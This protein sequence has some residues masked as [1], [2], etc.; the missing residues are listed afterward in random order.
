MPEFIEISINFCRALLQYRIDIFEIQDRIVFIC[1]LKMYNLLQHMYSND[2]NG[3]M[4]GLAAL[5]DLLCTY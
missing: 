5:N 3:S 1:I 4:I 2:T